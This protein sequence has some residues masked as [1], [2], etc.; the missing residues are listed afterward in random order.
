MSTTIKTNNNET[1]IKSDIPGLEERLARYALE[2][3]NVG[4]STIATKTDWDLSRFIRCSTRYESH[5]GILR[6]LIEKGSMTRSEM[7][8]AAG[9]ESGRELAGCRGSMSKNAKASKMPIDWWKDSWDQK[10]KEYVTELRHDVREAFKAAHQ[11]FE[12]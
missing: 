4:N 10:K 11:Q 12:K 3:I 9:K 6:Q 1:F 7:V 2:I 5:V 8:S